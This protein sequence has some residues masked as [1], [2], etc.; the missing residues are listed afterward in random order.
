[1]VAYG[2]MVVGFGLYV[3]QMCVRGWVCGSMCVVLLGGE[4]SELRG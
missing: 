3:G 1:V 2:G 4:E